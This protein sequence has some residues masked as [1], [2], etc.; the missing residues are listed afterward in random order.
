MRRIYSGGSPP[1]EWL[2]PETT[3]RIGG[4]PHRLLAEDDAQSEV[5]GTAL[6]VAI[7]VVVAATVGPFM[8]GVD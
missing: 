5:V 8:L 4:R 3:S 6:M 2:Y 1:P 7:T